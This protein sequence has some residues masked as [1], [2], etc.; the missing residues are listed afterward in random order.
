MFSMILIISYV[1]IIIYAKCDRTMEVN[2][3]ISAEEKSQPVIA[4]ITIFNQLQFLTQISN[5]Y[6]ISLKLYLLTSRSKFVT[7]M[8]LDCLP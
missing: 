1:S 5:P 7:I 3:S 8:M 6:E 2:C 4:N